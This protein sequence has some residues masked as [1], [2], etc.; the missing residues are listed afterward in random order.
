MDTLDHIAAVDLG[1]ESGRVV[2]ASVAR[3]RMSIQV[4]HR[5]ANRAIER[6]GQ[7]RWDLPALQAGILQRGFA[8]ADRLLNEDIDESFRNLFLSIIVAL[9]LVS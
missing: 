9:V 2:L 5:F 8:R 4:V 6:D 7:W 1:A 3:G